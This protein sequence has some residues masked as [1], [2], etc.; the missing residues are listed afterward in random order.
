MCMSAHVRS[1]N[2]RPV[3]YDTNMHA[4]DRQAPV[5]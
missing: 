3:K 5:V 4:T 2:V 1:V